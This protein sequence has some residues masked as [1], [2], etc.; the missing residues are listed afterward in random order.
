MA[1]AKETEV[2][3]STNR[4]A[5]APLL[6]ASGLIVGNGKWILSWYPVL[7]APEILYALIPGIPDL[8]AALFER[9]L[10]LVFLALAARRIL[11]SVGAPLGELSPNVGVALTVGVGLTF[12]ALIRVPLALGV[13]SGPE[14]ILFA[15]PG[16]LLAFAFFFFFLPFAGGIQQPL[17]ALARARVI[18][19]EDP[20]LPLKVIVTPLALETF[21]AALISSAAPDGSSRAVQAFAACFSGI[22]NALIPFIACAYAL[23]RMP[24]MEWET[25]KLDKYR[26]A[27]MS[28]LAI[29]GNSLLTS[30]LKTSNGV[31]LLIVSLFVMSGNFMRAASQAPDVKT[32]V[33]KIEIVADKL[34][35]ELSLDD[36]KLQ[37]RTFHPF[38]LSIAGE[39]RTVICA[40]ST[41]IRRTGDPAE[42]VGRLPGDSPKLGLTITFECTRSGKE[43]AA[44]QDLYLWHLNAKLVK[45]DMN[46]AVVR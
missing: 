4:E 22:G 35:L 15:L 29:A 20:L 31:L 33:N 44:L 6:F 18:V 9:T 28:T 8:F 37:F 41:S 34:T 36:E 38:A 46:A 14:I 1:K 30:A 10:A 45:L 13:V 23:L 5:E 27:R 32:V 11:L 39:T 43:L 21:I 40:K 2:T 16:L 7:I 42:I 25:Y 17:V 12:S 24:Q 3:G 19:R 26:H